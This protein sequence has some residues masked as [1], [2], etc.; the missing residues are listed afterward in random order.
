M[1]SDEVVFSIF[2]LGFDHVELMIFLV[3]DLLDFIFEERNFSIKS[4][5]L[6]LGLTSHVFE[7]EVLFFDFV[8]ELSDVELLQLIVTKL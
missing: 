7:L 2:I 8:L 1:S 6:K 5:I 4:F 3:F